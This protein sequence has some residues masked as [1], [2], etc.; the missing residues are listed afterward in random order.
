MPR[1]QALTVVVTRD[2][3]DRYRGFL[4]SVLAEVAPGTYVAANLTAGIRE[5]IWRV[6]CDWWE[7]L[8]GGSIL[9]ACAD[10]NAP[11]G[12]SVL[13]VGTPPI[14]IVEVDGVLLAC[15]GRRQNSPEERTG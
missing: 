12:I 6:V 13:A 15:A 3:A 4:S 11:S 8:P 2:V 9:M 10:K 14:R 1:K 7:E 5:R